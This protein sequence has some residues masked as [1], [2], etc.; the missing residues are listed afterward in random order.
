MTGFERSTSSR[1]HCSNEAGMMPELL[2]FRRFK[3]AAL[4][5]LRM[6]WLSCLNPGCTGGSGCAG[7]SEVFKTLRLCYQVK[8]V[9]R[10]ILSLCEASKPPRGFGLGRGKGRGCYPPKAL[11]LLVHLKRARGRCFQTVTFQ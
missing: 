5:T 10:L 11:Q 1:V 6:V 7:A 9:S 4:G 2:G 3:M 8:I